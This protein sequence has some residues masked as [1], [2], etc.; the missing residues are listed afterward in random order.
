MRMDSI[1][2]SGA[3]SLAWH[4]AKPAS[5]SQRSPRSKTSAASRVS[6]RAARAR[7]ALSPILSWIAW[8]SQIGFA[9]GFQ[10]V[11]CLCVRGGEPQGASGDAAA[12]RRHVDATERQPPG[13]L[14]EALAL[15]AADQV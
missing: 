1:E 15:D 3:A 14:Y 5:R 10:V 9:Q 12:A 11:G 8:C 4:L 7:V 6:R 2:F 13:R